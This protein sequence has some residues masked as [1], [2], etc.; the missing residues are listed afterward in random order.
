MQTEIVDGSLWK[1]ILEWSSNGFMMGCGS[2]SGSDTNHNDLGIVLGHAF[3]VLDVKDVDN[4]KFMQIR[5][6]HGN[7]GQEWTGDYSD[8]RYVICS[9]S[10]VCPQLT[11]QQRQVDQAAA[12]QAEDCRGGG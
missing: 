11:R 8:N 7:G 2:H 3:S 10:T 9:P 5:N 12:V 1:S 4:I 6:P